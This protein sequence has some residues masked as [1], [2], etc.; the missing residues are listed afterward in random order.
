M[1][2]C[3]LSEKAQRRRV[4]RELKVKDVVGSLS[5]GGWDYRGLSV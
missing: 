1:G 2:R 5:G 4:E 3:A